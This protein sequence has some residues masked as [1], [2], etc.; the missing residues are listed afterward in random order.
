MGNVS[1]ALPAIHPRISIDSYPATNHQAEFAP[2]C[3]TAAAD[4]A[5]LDGATAMAWTA[6]DLATD[7]RLRD[8][9][10]GR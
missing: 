4:Q 5:L 3:V 7:G 10:L 1:L 8:R 6:I 2:H 9:L